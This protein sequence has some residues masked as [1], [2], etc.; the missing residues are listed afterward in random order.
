MPEGVRRDRV[1]QCRGVRFPRGG[2]VLV[3][4]VGD[5]GATLSN[6]EPEA[7][8]YVPGAAD[9][10]R[11]H[12]YCMEKDDRWFVTATESLATQGDTEGTIHPNRRGHMLTSDLVR[13][14]GR[15]QRQ[16]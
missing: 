13:K 8:F 16:P 3:E 6:G 5:E 7:W 12:G 2:Y 15:N 14:A 9:K 10:F 1:R 11:K 4:D